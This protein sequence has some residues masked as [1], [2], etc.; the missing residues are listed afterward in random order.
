MK[1]TK[2]LIKNPKR[3]KIWKY[4]IFNMNFHL[5]GGLGVDFIDCY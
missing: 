5:N 4:K 2:L 3:D 1:M